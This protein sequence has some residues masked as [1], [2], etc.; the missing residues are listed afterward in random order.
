MAARAEAKLHHN[1]R[2]SDPCGTTTK[3]KPAF[4]RKDLRQMLEERIRFNTQVLRLDEYK[5]KKWAQSTVRLVEET[6]R[7]LRGR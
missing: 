7:E 1:G 3:T 4:T 2:D 5:A 6:D